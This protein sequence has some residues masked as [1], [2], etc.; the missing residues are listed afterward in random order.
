MIES[1]FPG[2]EKSADSQAESCHFQTPGEAGAY[3]KG[4]SAAGP[5]GSHRACCF[6][7]ID[8]LQHSFPRSDFIVSGAL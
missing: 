1:A 5:W 4:G 3:L 8:P 7:W 6:S 2:P